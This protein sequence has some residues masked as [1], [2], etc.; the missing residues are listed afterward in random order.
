MTA[1]CAGTASDDHHLFATGA[2]NSSLPGMGGVFNTTNCHLYHYAGNNPVRYT[3]PDGRDI[4]IST[5]SPKNQNE[6]LKG[7]QYLTDEVLD[8]EN[9]KVIINE[10]IQGDKAA[11]SELI[12]SLIENADVTISIKIGA[13]NSCFRPVD[14]SVP[15]GSSIEWQNCNSITPVFSG[16]KVKFG[17]TPKEINL[18]HELI[19][20]YHNMKGESKGN[21]LVRIGIYENPYK[22]NI[23]ITDIQHKTSDSLEEHITVFGD[24]ISENALRLEHNLPLRATY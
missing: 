21:M 3:D 17:V 12:R 22:Y 11:G 8:I 14:I 6:I 13:K 20:A 2:D 1:L 7:L 9:G 24:S 16:L 5:E 15:S 19:H 23:A 4:D 10:I 18:G